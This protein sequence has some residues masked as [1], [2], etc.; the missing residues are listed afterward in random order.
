MARTVDQGVLRNS[1]DPLELFRRLHRCLGVIPTARNAAEVVSQ[2]EIPFDAPDF[3]ERYLLREVLRKYPGWNLGIDCHQAAV[4]SFLDQEAVNQKTNLR[5]TEMAV[6]EKGV[7]QIIEIARRKVPF[8]LKDFKFDWFSDALRHGPGATT[9]LKRET[10]SLPNKLSG[11]PRVTAEAAN[12]AYAVLQ[13]MPS[14]AYNVSTSLSF[15]QLLVIQDYDKGTC[16]PK[17]AET[18]RFI[19]IQPDMNVLMQ[20]A[21]GTMLRRRL[22]PWG[23]NLQDQSINRRRAQ[24]AS[25][26]LKANAT[27]DLTNAS[28]SV[29]TEL[30]WRLIGDHDETQVTEG[31]LL[32]Y[33]MLNALR[34]KGGM[35]EGTYVEY[36]MFSANG[37]GYTFELETLC[38]WLLTTS[39]CQYLGIPEDVTVYGDDIVCPE[40]AVPLLKAVFDHC[41]FTLNTSKSH[42]NTVGPRFRESCGGHYLDGIDVTPFYVKDELNS[43]ET[44]ILLMN[45]IKR[46]SKLEHWG[47]DGRLK[48]VYDWLKGHLPSRAR[49]T[50]IP[51]SESNDG[52]IKDF[53][54]AHPRTYSRSSE[55]ATVEAWKWDKDSLRI[56]KTYKRQRVYFPKFWIGYEARTVAVTSRG[57]QTCGQTGVTTWLYLRYAK[58]FAPPVLKPLWRTL[59]GRIVGDGSHLS[60]PPL[61][62]KVNGLKKELRYSQRVVREWMNTGPWLPPEPCTIVQDEIIQHMVDL[63]SNWECRT[64]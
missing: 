44:V 47:L 24:E 14:W 21:M 54:E 1:V 40:A 27:V 28:N 62:Y 49:D 48:P 7:L 38:F 64:Q 3:R 43:I 37:N 63:L 5:L 4:Q 17:N 42:F 36:E 22:Y 12:L 25:K 10:A 19:T 50:E 23:I 57:T 33:K 35:V 51:F 16:V 31:F 32:W 58:A 41:G 55:M 60:D 39:V 13:S 6:P 11:N 52:L 26:G 20:L 9:R 30:V 34:T 15:D 8:I 18:D 56:V 59:H 45:N 53:D 29:V 2:Q 61:P 46:W